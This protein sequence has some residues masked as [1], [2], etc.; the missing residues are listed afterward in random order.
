M[1]MID[2]QCSLLGR[3]IFPLCLFYSSLVFSFHFDEESSGDAKWDNPGTYV[4]EIGGEIF[5]AFDAV[6]N[7]WMGGLAAIMVD[8]DVRVNNRLSLFGAFHFDSDVWHDFMNKPAFQRQEEGFAY[9]IELEVEEFFITWLAFPGKMELTAGRMFSVISYANQLHLADFQFNMKP[10]IFTDYFGS[11]HGLALD[12]FSSKFYTSNDLL[13]ASVFVEAAKN[14][15]DRDLLVLTGTTDLIVRMDDVSYGFRAFGY[16]D[17]QR[18]DHPAFMYIPSS[19]LPFMVDLK[20][21]FGLNAWG[22]G[23]HLL[24]EMQTHSS[25][26]FQSEFVSRSLG[27]EFLRGG[28]AFLIF[29][30]TPKLSSSFMFQQLEIPLF[31]EKGWSTATETAYTFGLSYF[32]FEGNRLRIEYSRFHDSPF[33][34]HMLLAK[35]TFFLDLG[36]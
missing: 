3:M 19:E 36:R 16:F 8:V 31:R 32:P 22:A 23:I 11:N 27:E 24:W 12:G 18:S 5:S 33:Y 25:I 35:W 28:Y 17:H 6:D 2:A 10:R 7:H 26:F 14:G 21:G 34:N 29:S 20:D 1:K 4:I 15:F 30:H 9:D 13:T